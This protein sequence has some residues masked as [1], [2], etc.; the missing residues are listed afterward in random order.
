MERWGF[1]VQTTAAEFMA[2]LKQYSQ[3]TP[4]RSLATPQGQL[5]VEAAHPYLGMSLVS[6]MDMDGVLTHPTGVTERLPS[7]IQVS[8]R[9]IG[10]GKSIEVLATNEHMASAPYMVQ[11]LMAAVAHWQPANDAIWTHQLPSQEHMLAELRLKT[12][13]HGF[14]TALGNFARAYHDEEVRSVS[15]TER[16]DLL[17]PGRLTDRHGKTLDPKQQRSW[18]MT[19]NLH[20]SEM[21]TQE[22][23]TIGHLELDCEVSRTR[24]KYPWHLTLTCRGTRYYELEPFVAAFLT[25]CRATWAT[26]PIQE[27]PAA[28]PSPNPPAPSAP[29]AAS[30][31]SAPPQG[32]KPPWE[33]IPDHEW[34]RKALKLWWEDYPGPEI[35]QQLHVAHK[36]VTNQLSLLRKLYGEALVPTEQQRRKWRRKGQR[37]GE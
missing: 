9:P 27:V 23:G 8:V 24:G 32:E 16:R 10:R 25:H 31:E 29:S 12:R 37:L 4:A 30:L 13:L 20:P 22:I 2:W 35:S 36:T 21:A 15:I 3:T 6:R 17:R 19:L 33:Q 34:D 26:A 1:Y 28:E 14:E 11:L 7:L 5:T 18:M